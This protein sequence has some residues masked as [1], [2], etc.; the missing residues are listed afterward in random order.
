MKGY[1][2]KHIAEPILT[3]WVVM[4]HENGGSNSP[5]YFKSEKEAEAFVGKLK[6]K[7]KE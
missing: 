3:V 7:G 5:L 6:K 2:I 4:V 1:T